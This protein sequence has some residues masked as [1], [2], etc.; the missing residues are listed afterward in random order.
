MQCSVQTVAVAHKEEEETETIVVGK[1]DVIQITDLANTFFFQF[2]DVTIAFFYN[3]YHSVSVHFVGRRG[4]L[5]VQSR[6]RDEFQR[7]LQLL[8]QDVAVS[9]HAGHPPDPRRNAR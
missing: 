1:M 4:D 7:H 8:R 6:E 5:R 3:Q 2:G 9:K